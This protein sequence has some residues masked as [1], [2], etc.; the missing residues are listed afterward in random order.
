M[1]EYIGLDVSLE[2]TT[3]SIRRDGQRIWR[4]KCKSDP[5]VI[6]TLVRKRAPGAKRMVF[7]TGPLSVWFYHALS[8]EGLPAICIDAR[9]AKA[10][11][12]MAANK[13]DANDAD[14][15]AQLAEAGFYREVRVKGYDS[16]LTRTLVA[17]R[18]KL[19]RICTEL[20]NQIRGLMK[21]F[22]LI[23]P[24][25][26]GRTF[27]QNVRELLDG[28]KALSPIVVTILEAWCGMRKQAAKLSRQLMAIARES[29]LSP[30]F[31]DGLKDQAAAVWV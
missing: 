2:E 23:V 28:N 1:D 15:L 31:G 27:E 5:N 16:M 7:E 13:T 3:I 22:G 14:G 26:R 12:N 25:G 24:P 30:I 10:V 18:T 17:A 9:H 6:S 21:T 29:E 11:L 19:V 8:A 20:S 4:G